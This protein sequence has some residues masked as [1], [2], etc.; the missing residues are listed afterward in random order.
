[1]NRLVQKNV[2]LFEFPV[3]AAAGQTDQPMLSQSA[4]FGE[5]KL[6]SLNL[7]AFFRSTLYL[8]NMFSCC[9]SSVHAMSS[10]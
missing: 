9:S 5:V 1:M 2:S 7:A 4:N 10:S 6:N 8:Q 3:F